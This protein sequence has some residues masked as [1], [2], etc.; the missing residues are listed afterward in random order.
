MVLRLLP[1]LLLASPAAAAITAAQKREAQSLAAA[2][3]AA[4]EAFPTGDTARDELRMLR[5]KLFSLGDIE[6]AMTPA[7]WDA[8]LKALLDADYYG[9]DDL[10][11]L[12]KPHLPPDGIGGES[13]S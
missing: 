5:N 7:E 9:V 3:A 4:V 11:A 6:A 10:T 12:L 1:L 13:C 8:S 2:A